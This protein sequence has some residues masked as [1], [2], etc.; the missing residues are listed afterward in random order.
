MPVPIL[1]LL[2]LAAVY[3]AASTTSN[4]WLTALA[5]AALLMA[6]PLIR[7]FRKN[8]YFRSEHFQTLKSEIASLVNEHNDVVNYVEQ[9]RAQGAFELG[10][11]STG[12]YAHL[13]SFENI[14]AWNNRRD[15][16]VAE[17]AP[18]VHN[19]S[20]QVVRNASADPSNT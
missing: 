1:I 5:L 6:N 20:L 10:S 19:A 17:Y 7:S 15:R 3:V 9:I 16:N 11:S 18:Q 2:C 13:A 8:L 14:S 12:Q 4:F